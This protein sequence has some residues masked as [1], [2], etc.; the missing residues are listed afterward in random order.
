MKKIL[1]FCAAGVF[2]FSALSAFS[3]NGTE[4]A[5]QMMRAY[6]DGFYPGVVRYADE[7]LNDNSNS[8]YMLKAALLKGESLFKLGRTNEALE[9]LLR[10][11]A[12]LKQNDDVPAELCFWTGR[13]YFEQKKDEEA[14]S[15]FYRAAEK[16]K[17]AENIYGQAVFYLGKVC[18]RM[19]K[20][21]QAADYFEFVLQ[22]GRS[23][24][25]SDY[26]EACVSFF[27]CAVLAQKNEKCENYFVQLE[28]AG[29][30]PA[31]KYRIL[32]AYAQSLE[33]SKEYAKA[34]DLYVKILAEGPDFLSA[35]TMQRAYLVSSGHRTEVKQDAG[36]VIERA[37]GLK[38][39]NPQLVS[40]FWTRLAVDAFNSK[41]YEKS[42]LYFDNAKEDSSVQLKQLALIYTTE[43]NFLTSKK[44]QKQAAAEALL[45]LENGWKECEFSENQLFYDDAMAAKTRYAALSED[46]K[47]T[48]EYAKPQIEK[49][50]SD[51]NPQIKKSSVYWMALALYSTQKYEEAAEL[52]EANPYLDDEFLL[53][54]AKS[55]AKC[56][57]SSPA[58]KIF[59]E[60]LAK[61]SLDNDGKLD[62]TRTLLTAGHL[63]SAVEQ[64]DSAAGLEASYMKG[65][66]LFNRRE[67]AEA[68]KCFVQAAGQKALE[69]K[70]SELS[71]FY[72]GY[73]QYQLE[74]Y[75]K[76][77]ANLSSFIKAGNEKSLLRVA[78]V[79]ASRCAVQLSKK[80]E[81]VTFARKS[82]ENAKSQAEENESVLLLSGIHS[83]FADYEKAVEVLSPYAQQK[84]DFG[85][86]CLYL[87]AQI[88]VQKKDFDRADECYAELA[89][90]KKAGALAEEAVFRRGELF[91]TNGKYTQALPLFENYL[92]NY[93]SGRFSDAAM[94]FE[95]DSL[96]KTGQKDRA[97]LYFEQIVENHTTSTYKYAAEKQLV[98]LFRADGEYSKA[99]QM[100][101]KMLD[102]YG[103]QAEEDEISS[104]KK[105][106]EALES[107]A[108]EKIIKKESEY[109]KAGSLKTPEGRICGT[110]LVKL[111]AASPSGTEKAE[112]LAVSLLKS[113][114]KNEWEAEYA[115][116][117]AEF[118]A[119]LYRNQSKNA[120]SAQYFLTAARSA[121]K[122]GKN[123]EAARCLYGAAEAF[124]AA[125]K[126][127]D[128]KST[129]EL[130]QKLYPS[131]AYSADVRKLLNY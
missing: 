78:C 22:N 20:F 126:A 58:D 73:C 39:H 16:S 43:I 129:A 62:Y 10:T 21:E 26:E 41:D 93:S 51:R 3:Q 14:F 56:G 46:W 12:Q 15:Y 98:E 106:L 49:E 17:P 113:Q 112:K 111:Y 23:F 88:Y 118:L 47:K 36:A 11:E 94:Y 28:N 38:K 7:V 82:L 2:C 127:G 100:A 4:A 99:V 33:N 117:N 131:S 79:T 91:Y 84:N 52:L 55:L 32:F 130:L 80:T 34:Y 63:Y 90:Q 1:Y 89:S 67:W 68:E 59:Y 8:P 70:Y 101:Q 87:S 44:S 74:N 57:K 110:E 114:E 42:L 24:T 120:D 25:M 128:A 35:A 71:V 72:L 77:L 121:R 64:A 108:D 76:A 45:A 92:K 86:E 60:L 115:F 95:A 103:K 31:A 50:N 102:E 29:F 27:E 104:I 40:E 37:G 122:C 18:R 9:I 81:A 85:F 119:V 5:A 65:L 107:G 13:V 125:K 48:L 116:E 124:D 109:S 19:Q 69:Q 105:E 53:L 123:D 66:A 61:G 83:D 6:S 96:L 75:E 54:K 30:S 97:S